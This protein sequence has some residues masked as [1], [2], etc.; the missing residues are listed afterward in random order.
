M[1]FASLVESRLSV[2][3]YTTQPIEEQ[4]IE[5]ILEAARLA[6]SAHNFQPWR[7][8]VITSEKG[9]NAI[10]ACY[11]REWIKPVPLFLL[12]CGNRN[13]SWK[14]PTDGKDH[15]DIDLGIAIEHIC[16]AA[17]EEELGSCI[18]CNFD[19]VLCRTSFNLPEHMEPA[20]IIPIGYP[21]NPDIFTNSP[22][23]RKGI[24][25]VVLRETF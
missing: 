25:E 20:A 21:A 19:T 1:T 7:F 4:K 3:N 18:I 10:A 9:R 11:P 15:L 24:S 23:K 2:R 13:E 6:P 14:R 5:R 22:K 16:L 17:T 8:V 12:V